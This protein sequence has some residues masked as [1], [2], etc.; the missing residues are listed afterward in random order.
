[1]LR[2]PIE[3]DPRVR[4]RA[5]FHCDI[6]TPPG[7]LARRFP[8]IDFSSLEDPWWHDHLALDRAETES[9]VGARAACFRRDM[10]ALPDWRGVAVVTHWGFVRALTGRQAQNGE[11][12]FFDPA[13]P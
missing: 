9:E 6:G 3:V 11:V 8:D 7:Q 1:V 5:A 4:E 13:A 10:A 2:L 12:M